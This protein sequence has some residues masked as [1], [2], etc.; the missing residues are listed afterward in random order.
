MIATVADPEQVQ[1]ALVQ[2]LA[3]IRCCCLHPKRAHAGVN[4]TD[5]HPPACTDCHGWAA[6]R[7]RHIARWFFLAAGARGRLD[8]GGRWQVQASADQYAQVGIWLE[9]LERLAT[10]KDPEHPPPA[11]PAA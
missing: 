2:S 8:A 10:G 1:R 6:I 4:T 7:A 5:G 9:Q 11:D 3:R